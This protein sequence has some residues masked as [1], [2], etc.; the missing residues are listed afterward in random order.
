MPPA[1]ARSTEVVHLLPA[2]I[3]IVVALT[4]VLAISARVQVPFWPVPMT[5]QTLA[6]L[7]IAGLAGPATAGAAMLGYLAEGAA[8]LPVFAGTPAHGVGLAYL[9]GPTG[10]YLVGMLAA[11][12]VV[13]VMVRQAAGRV[14]LIGAA[15]V[16]GSLVVY[17]AGAAWLAQFVGLDR[18]IE[19]GVVPFLLGDA[20]K[21]TL[22]T[23]LVL[24]LGRAA[25]APE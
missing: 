15:M 23:A 9:M 1:A 3:A 7:T 17:A 18:A 19:A 6:V 21:A 2:R 4:L 5:L 13:G 25:R 16:A 11:S 8:G 12:V 22:A 20:V 24:A 14:L 10:G